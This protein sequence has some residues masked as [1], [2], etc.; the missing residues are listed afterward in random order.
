MKLFLK[1][2]ISRSDSSEL[3]RFGH[4]TL[5]PARTAG[6]PSPLGCLPPKFQGLGISLANDVIG[7]D[8]HQPFLSSKPYLYP[9]SPAAD[10]NNLPRNPLK[11]PAR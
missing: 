9:N 10:P 5:Q 4:C 2:I 7:I 3:Q 8:I 6:G 11:P 1:N